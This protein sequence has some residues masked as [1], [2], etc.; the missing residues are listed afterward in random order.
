[1]SAVTAEHL[2]QVRHPIPQ[3][4]EPCAHPA[5]ADRVGTSTSGSAVA[6]RD[7]Y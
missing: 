5:P 7:P 6:V 2:R 1:M 4:T 3:G